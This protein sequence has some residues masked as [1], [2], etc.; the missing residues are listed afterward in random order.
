MK[1]II[2]V[3]FIIISTSAFGQQPQIDKNFVS[4]FTKALD[5]NF[6]AEQ[7]NKMFRDY[8]GIL[9]PGSDVTQLSE[10]LKGHKL[11]IYPLHDFKSQKLYTDNIINLLN[12]KN[13]NQRILA[14][15]VIASSGDTSKEDILLEKIKTETGKGNLI[16]CGMALLY[17]N[18][19]HTTPLFD[20]LVKNEE[21]GDAHMI[22]L[23]IKLNKDSLQQTAY[24]RI[25]STDVKAKVLAAQ[26]LSVTPLNIKTETLLKQ[27]VKEWDI[28][29]KGYAIYTVGQLQ[30]GSLLQTLEPLL[31]N[32]KTRRISLEALANSPTPEDRN[33]LLQLIN[34]QDTVSEDLL[35]CLFKSKNVDNLEVWLKLLYTKP[36]PKDYY[37][38]VFKQP[39][40]QT[41]IVL[42]TL[43]NTLTQIKDPDILGE[44]VRAL[45][46]KIDDKSMDI[47]IALLKN[48]NK[49]VRYWT[50]K[51]LEDNG[52]SRL[53]DEETKRLLTNGLQDGN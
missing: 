37:F 33:Y 44:L 48:E 38:A 30:I 28:N 40:L 7:L 50:A 13:S 41:E 35:D 24:S 21:F 10:T 9:T 43:Q 29:I 36:I 15:L 17:L 31:N 45:E 27:A 51:T 12:S 39:L 46:G 3:L 6:S 26:I 14:Y 1:K 5:K 20:F 16:W 8:S 11:A 2:W 47:M 4:D 19:S 34:K 25:N 42:P 52:S 53:K 18:A 23:F 32:Q 49:T 22:P